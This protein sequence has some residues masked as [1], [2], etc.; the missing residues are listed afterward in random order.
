M[1]KMVTD[2]MFTTVVVGSASLLKADLERSGKVQI[3]G[4]RDALPI[5]P[6]RVPDSL[7]TPKK[8]P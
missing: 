3:L 2:P 1:S 8:N 5:Q 7:K 6:P 4:E